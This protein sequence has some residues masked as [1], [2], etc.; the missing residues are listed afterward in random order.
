[1]RC[2]L[3]TLTLT[4]LLAATS[5][6]AQTPPCNAGIHTA[7]GETVIP[8]S[9]G[10]ITYCIS[11]FGW[12]DTWL[13]GTPA[14]YNLALDLLSGDD[15]FNLKYNTPAGL[16]G[17]GTGWLSPSLDAGTLSAQDAPGWSPR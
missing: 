10:Q 13:L 6:D 11:D 1:M 4:G 12:S 16:L 9:N 7:L 15:A 2:F 5:V 3:L 14:T 17:P 8:L